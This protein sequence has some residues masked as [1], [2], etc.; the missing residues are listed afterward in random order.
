MVARVLLGIYLG[1][2]HVNYMSG[3][4]VLIVKHPA[5]NLDCI[6][7]DFCIVGIGYSHGF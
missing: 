1:F 4:D 7:W 3:N 2:G 6:Y 5:N